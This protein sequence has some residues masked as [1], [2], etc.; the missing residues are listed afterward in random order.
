MIGDSGVSVIVGSDLD[1]PSRDTAAYG[2]HCPFT[3]GR[4][5]HS[6]TLQRETVSNTHTLHITHTE[7][8]EP[9][10]GGHFASPVAERLSN[11]TRRERERSE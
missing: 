11:S 10:P 5:W 9:S 7:R 6:N 8:E 1:G 4:P 2:S 3:M